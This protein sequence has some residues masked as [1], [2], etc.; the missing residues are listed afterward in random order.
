MSGGHKAIQPAR[1]N[2]GSLAREW[3]S[4]LQDTMVTREGDFFYSLAEP[5][6][7]SIM[8][9]DNDTFYSRIPTLSDDELLN[10][11]THYSQYKMEAVQLAIT[12]L[13]SRGFILSEDVLSNIA[14]FFS[15]TSNRTSR[16]INFNPALFRLISYVIF[17]VGIL[18]AVAI[19]FTAHPPVEN[20]LGYNP[21][22]TKKYLRE[23]EVYG[24]KSNTLATEF[25]EWF[26]GLWQGKNLSYTIACITVTISIVIWLIGSR[27]DSGN[28][29]HVTPYP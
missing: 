11:I 3:P 22:D 28:S 16:P 18:V 9:Q 4:H 12:V 10:Y 7:V 21:L 6:N 19:Y 8:N 20:P 25:R 2:R 26:V 29:G 24:G 15:L 5:Q 1:H 23:L 14:S 17:S 27:K 13:R